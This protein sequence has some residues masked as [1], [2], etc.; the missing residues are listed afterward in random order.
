MTLGIVRICGMASLRAVTVYSWSS[1]TFPR[2]SS[3]RSQ[4]P[5]SS[6][7]PDEFH[8]RV[9]Q[10]CARSA[11]PYQN[12]TAQSGERR[13]ELLS[14]RLVLLPDIA[15]R[16]SARRASMNLFRASL[17]TDDRRLFRRRS[18]AARASRPSRGSCGLTAGAHVS[19]WDCLPEVRPRT[20]AP[21][22][23]IDLE[24]L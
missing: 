15:R 1:V 19:G 16:H 5:S 4:S 11:H 20:E 14:D 24:H 12:S 8:E 9:I 18:C 2:C 13:H 10:T 3:L 22:A 23:L 6:A 17:T 7:Q 21:D